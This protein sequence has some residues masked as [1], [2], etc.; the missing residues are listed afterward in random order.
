MKWIEAVTNEAGPSDFGQ[1]TIHEWLK[2]GVVLCNVINCL[3]PGSVK[4]IH[5]SKMAF[6][7]VIEFKYTTLKIALVCCLH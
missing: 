7:M 5:D 4:K 2:N 1:K 3:S 6:K